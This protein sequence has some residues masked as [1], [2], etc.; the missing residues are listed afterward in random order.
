MILGAASLC[1]VLLG[2]RAGA[3][4]AQVGRRRGV[5]GAVPTGGPRS[6]AGRGVRF[7]GAVGRRHCA[8]GRRCST[9]FARVSRWSFRLPG[10]SLVLAGNTGSIAWGIEY[11]I[12]ALAIGLLV[13]HS[14]RR[15]PHLRARRCFLGALHQ[16]RVSSLMGATILFS[17]VVQAGALGLLQ[18]LGV[19]IVVWYVSFWLASASAS[20]KSWR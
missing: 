10:C 16:D 14:R 3:A 20:T 7:L 6:V 19:V 12:F 18:A 17:D 9:V 13:S 2:D 8:S 15:P 1:A 4:R 11:V 5:V